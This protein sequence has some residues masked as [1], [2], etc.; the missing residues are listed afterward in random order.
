MDIVWKKPWGYH[1]YHQQQYLQYRVV[2]GFIVQQR[3]PGTIQP[4][5]WPGEIAINFHCS[6]AWLIFYDKI[7]MF[8]DFHDL[9]IKNP[10]VSYQN[11]TQNQTSETIWD[12]ACHGQHKDDHFT[13]VPMT[14]G[15]CGV[16][17]TFLD[18]R[19]V[20][21]AIE[22]GMKSWPW[23]T[24]FNRDLH[25]IQMGLRAERSHWLCSKREKISTSDLHISRTSDDWLILD[26]LDRWWYFGYLWIGS[27]FVDRLWSKKNNT[28]MFFGISQ[29]SVVL[30]NAGSQTRRWDGWTSH[31]PRS[32]RKGLAHP[33]CQRKSTIHTL[34]GQ[35][36]LRMPNVLGPMNI[37]DSGNGFA[38]MF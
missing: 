31:L 11:Q 35:S 28:R 25:Q 36:R 9:K 27:K 3:I 14:N 29:R 2:L 24:E 21:S 7:C 5:T 37:C 8:Q 17:T 22:N 32:R 12:H 30:L 38:T 23:W 20:V 15:G 1:C 13:N 19:Y 4:V 16:N 18:W 26:H 33:S 34:T 6:T 10:S